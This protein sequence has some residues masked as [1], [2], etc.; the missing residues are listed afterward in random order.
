MVGMY[1]NVHATFAQYTDRRYSFSVLRGVLQGCPLSSVAYL[2]AKECISL[3]LDSVFRP[4]PSLA[5]LCADDLAVVAVTKNQL[6]RLHWIFVK[7]E[8]AAGLVLNP[9][10]TVLVPLALKWYDLT[11]PQLRL[12][13]EALTVFRDILG[14]IS[15]LWREIRVDSKG[16]YLGV[17][18]GPCADQYNWIPQIAK[19]VERSKEIANSGAILAQGKIWLKTEKS[20][21]KFGN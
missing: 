7:M 18:L 6:E 2:L 5:R 19:Y 21:Q 20:L 11:S 10:K 1:S 3:W 12:L 14:S 17:F 16:K 15:A 9:R 8:A 13:P 4:F